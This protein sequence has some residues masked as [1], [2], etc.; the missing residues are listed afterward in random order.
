MY[1]QQSAS[2]RALSH[3]LPRRSPASTREWLWAPTRRHQNWPRARIRVEKS[4][5]LGQGDLRYRAVTLS[6][7]AEERNLAIYRELALADVSAEYEQA[8]QS[9]PVR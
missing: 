1:F 3:L 9:F 2:T 4:D 8:M 6:G 7:H 5:V